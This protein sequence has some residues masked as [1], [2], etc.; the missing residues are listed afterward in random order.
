[1]TEPENPRSPV[2]PLK[3]A[4]RYVHRTPNAMKVMRHRGRGPACFLHEGRL[5]YYVADLDAWLAASAAADTHFNEVS[6]KRV[7]PQARRNRKP[8]IRQTQNAA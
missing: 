7:P 2:L 1:M 5:M 6:A 3:D 4:A 8:A